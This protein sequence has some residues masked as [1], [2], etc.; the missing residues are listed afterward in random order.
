ML[1]VGATATLRAEEALM[2]HRRLEDPLG[3][4]HSQLMLASSVAGDD[5]VRAQQLYDESA[6]A[7]R[8]LGD[9]HNVL[10][11]NRGLAYAYMSLGERE[12]GRALH[13]DNL[14]HARTLS[15]E[16]IEAITLGALAMFAV[17]DGRLEDAVSMLKESHRLHRD[18]GDPLQ[19]A[20]DVFRF[21]HLLAA[22]GRAETATQ[23]FASADALCEEIGFS[24]RSWDPEFIDETL[25]MI[26]ARLDEAAFAE[27][28]EEGRVLTAD[29]AVA[30]ALEEPD[31]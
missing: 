26:H 10:I 24:L 23:V 14:L 13:E 22:Q 18:V 30:L 12:R 11:A 1:A 4:A 3:T 15:N 25:A 7:F 5:M 29:E 9:E 27:A 16:R 2:L 21:A 6:R 28:W 31:G 17:E 19:S 20:F 8:R